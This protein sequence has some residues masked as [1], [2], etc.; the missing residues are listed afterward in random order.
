MK[1]RLALILALAMLC[2]AFLG[3]APASA[4]TSRSLSLTVGATQTIDLGGAVSIDYTGTNQNVAGFV[5]DGNNLKVTGYAYGTTSA[6]IKVTTAA[7]TEEIIYTVVVSGSSSALRDVS[8]VDF[9]FNYGYTSRSD[10]FVDET[11]TATAVAKDA[12]GAN[13]NYYTRF[14][15]EV[16]TGNATITSGSTGSTVT[17]KVTQGSGS[18]RNVG[19]KCTAYGSNNTSAAMEKGTDILAYGGTVNFTYVD[20]DNSGASTNAGIAQLT[21]LPRSYNVSSVPVNIGTRVVDANPSTARFY[22]GSC[23]VNAVVGVRKSSGGGSY[24][25][26]GSGTGVV[27]NNV[28]LSNGY[29]I[30]A[31]TEAANALPVLAPKTTGQITNAMLGGLPADANWLAY[32][33]G[34]PSVAIVSGTTLIGVKQGVTQLYVYY[35]LNPSA[36]I[37]IK[38]I[39]VLSELPDGSGGAVVNPEDQV[40][41]LGLTSFSSGKVGKTYRLNKIT[42]DGEKIDPDELTWTT[43]NKK[44]ATVKTPGKIKIVGKGTCYIYAVTEG[45]AQAKM[46]V[47]VK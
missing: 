19:L 3:I 11:F 47:T 13:I 17:V 34:D 9:T 16:T 18:G 36:P 32:K 6:K 39:I 12:A 22:A 43:S 7:G 15:W 5:A 20:R 40:L 25:W 10:L 23:V 24:P 28:T 2:T 29:T 33:V 21:N 27:N 46:K 31:I 35:A 26:Y 45:G 30:N 1:K 41:S 4:A 8:S 14:V 42:L 37:I 44:V 38:N